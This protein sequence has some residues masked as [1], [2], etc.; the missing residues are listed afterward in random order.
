MSAERVHKLIGNGGWSR[1]HVTDLLPA[2]LALGLVLDDWVTSEMLVNRCEDV[3]GEPNAEEVDKL[4]E[5]NPI[6]L[7]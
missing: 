3:K 2:V 1:Y 5:E 7:S 4:V 6:F